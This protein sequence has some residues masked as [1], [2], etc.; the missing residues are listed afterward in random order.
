MSQR[1]IFVIINVKICKI[2]QV[3]YINIKDK[4]HIYL[5]LDCLTIFLD[6]CTLL[7]IFLYVKI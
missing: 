3:M 6:I 5:G 1:S 7:V 2:L 4:T